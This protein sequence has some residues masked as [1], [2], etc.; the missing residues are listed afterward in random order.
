MNSPFS[1][2]IDNITTI[3]N[4]VTLHDMIVGYT[5]HLKLHWGQILS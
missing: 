2:I 3:T 1:D 4:R 5:S